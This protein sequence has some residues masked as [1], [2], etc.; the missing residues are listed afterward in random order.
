[1][2]DRPHH[3]DRPSDHP[4]DDQGDYQPA[5]HRPPTDADV[6]EAIDAVDRM[7]DV[8]DGFEAYVV[9]AAGR[10]RHGTRYRLNLLWIH[11]FA[12]LMI[13][14]ML[15]LTG[16]EGLNGPS[17]AFL[18]TLPGV[19]YSLSTVLGLGGFL[20]GIGCVFRAKRVEQAGLALL[21]MFYTLLA[22]SFAVPPVEWALHGGLT[23]PPMYSPVVYAHL[24]VIMAVHI[25][26]LGVRRRD[27]QVASAAMMGVMPDDREVSAA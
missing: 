10:D 5:H 11:A 26:A 15:S 16:R 9:H 27:E 3:P 1:M 12:A 18:R 13:A 14:P 17:F 21:M 7:L 24:T 20:L 23:K 8:V 2:S 25:W 19:P 6:E 22:V 4:S